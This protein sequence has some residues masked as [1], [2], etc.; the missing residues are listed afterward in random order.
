MPLLNMT[1]AARAAG[2]S[3]SQFYAGYVKPG[4]VSVDRS[5]PKK[6]K[7]DTSE[8]IRVFG[9]IQAD[10]TVSDKSG[11]DKTPENTA[12]YTDDLTQ[13]VKELREKLDAAERDTDLLKKELRMTSEHLA[14]VREDRDKWRDQAQHQQKLLTSGQDNRERQDRELKAMIDE[15]REQVDDLKGRGLFW[16]MRKKNKTTGQTPVQTLQDTG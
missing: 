5:D 16:W 4:T 13:T 14:D 9:T 1:E 2:L 8:I 6:P 7:V 15:L 3:R 10:N 12:P 11:Q